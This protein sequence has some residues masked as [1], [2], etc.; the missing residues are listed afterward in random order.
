MKQAEDQKAST[1]ETSGID[2]NELVTRL[3]EEL[4]QQFKENLLKEYGMTAEQIT[5]SAYMLNWISYPKYHPVKGTVCI[6]KVQRENELDWDK[7]VYDGKQWQGVEGT[8]IAWRT[9]PEL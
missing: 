5:R 8:V 7:A 9:S 1:I 2:E 4:L 3:T 6:V